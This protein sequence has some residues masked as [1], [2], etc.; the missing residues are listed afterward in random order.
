MTYRPLDA[1]VFPGLIEARDFEVSD[2][3]RILALQGDWELVKQTGPTGGRYVIAK[4]DNAHQA[5]VTLLD[6]ISNSDVQLAMAPELAIPVST[7]ANI[8]SPSR[9]A[10]TA[11][12]SGRASLV[13]EFLSDRSSCER[14]KSLCRHGATRLKD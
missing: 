5:G 8:I 10:R 3:I 12:G 6:R 4:P 14:V 1:D 2:E 11:L 9:A 13:R 7:V